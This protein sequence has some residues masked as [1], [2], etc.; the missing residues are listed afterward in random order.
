MAKANIT[1]QL[2]ESLANKDNS[3]FVRSVNEKV[4]N[5]IALAVE[6]LASKVSYIT[7]DNVVLQPINETFNDA[8]VD[9]SNYVYLLGIE[10]PQLEINTIKK[11]GF[12]KGI[13]KKLIYFWKNRKF[14]KM[15]KKR[16]RKKK[17]EDNSLEEKS[18]ASLNQNQYTIFDL[19]E[20]LQ[21]SLINFLA[22]SSIVYLNK[23]A[24]QIIGKED[25]GSNVKIMVYLTIIDGQIHKQY[26]N[27]KQG[28]IN[29]NLL[30]R[31]R[32]TGDKHSVVGNNF[33]KMLKIFNSLYFNINNYLPNQIFVESI[34]CACPDEL[35]EGDDIYKVYLKIVNFLSLK[36]IRGIKSIN[37]PLK[38]IHEDKI[39]GNCG[40]DFNK[41]LE[42]LGK[43]KI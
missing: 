25:F 28:F 18:F 21:Q 32:F 30:N 17:K 3:N 36:T 4:N 14:L 7:L 24:L 34:L 27:Q 41:M 26:L 37:D 42:E 22:E 9:G 31:Y 5:V 6:H 23:N 19:T 16:F 8:F 12:W 39:C 1:K 13:K 15:K 35:F 10:N 20:D 29:I 38:T 43:N 40:V 33:V 2:I 11:E